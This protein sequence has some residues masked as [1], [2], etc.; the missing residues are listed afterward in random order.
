MTD[1]LVA[2]GN[3]CNLC[4]IV[5]AADGFADGFETVDADC[6]GFVDT[7][8]KNDGVGARRYVFAAFFN[9]RLSENYRRSRAVAR[10]VVG[11]RGNFFDYLRAHVFKRVGKFYFFCDRHAVVGDKRTAVFAL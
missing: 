7:L 11:L 9:D 3:T 2:R 5:F 10:Y 4:N 1:N 8:F 6:N